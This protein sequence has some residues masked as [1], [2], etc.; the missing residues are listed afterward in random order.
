MKRIIRVIAMLLGIC[1]CAYPLMASLLEQKSQGKVLSTYEDEVKKYDEDGLEQF[2]QKAKEYNKELYELGNFG[3]SGTRDSVLNNEGYNKNLNY[4]GNGVMGKIEIPEINVCLPIYHGTGEDVLSVGVG[5]LEGTSLPV[6][7]ENTHCVLTGHRGLP[8][9][10]LFTRLDEL[11][12]EDLFFI[13]VGQQVMAY[14]ITEIEVIAPDNVR[15]LSVE[16]QKDKVSLVTCTPYGVNSHRL[17][18]TGERT[19]YQEEVYLQI[20]PKIASEREIIF[21]ALPFG[22]IGI[23]VAKMIIERRKRKRE[24]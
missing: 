19:E 7:G 17:V 20:E 18:V 2:I 5:H 14:R 16:P 1:L 24:K 15:G 8:N 10:K 3:V 11:E 4:S 13:E 9:S 12:K 23:V 6:G 22:M 21:A